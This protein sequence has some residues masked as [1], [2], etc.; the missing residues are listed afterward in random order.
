MPDGEDTKMSMTEYRN[1]R[2]K[3][4]LD[5]PCSRIPTKLIQ[6]NGS[7]LQVAGNCEFSTVLSVVS[8]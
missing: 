6:I 7:K 3:R 2:R 4:Q 5:T 1:T 8:K